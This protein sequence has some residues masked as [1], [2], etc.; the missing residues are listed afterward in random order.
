M[1]REYQKARDTLLDCLEA[2]EA[3]RN[4]VVIV[5]AQAIYL[6]VPQATGGAEHFTTDADIALLPGELAES[7]ALG[8]ALATKGQRSMTRLGSIFRKMWCSA[9]ATNRLEGR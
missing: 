7:P 9:T 4:S 8:D 2:L 1:S 3:H 5:G 6:Q